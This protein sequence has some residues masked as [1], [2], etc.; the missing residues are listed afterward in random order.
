MR[1]PD[2]WGVKRPAATALGLFAALLAATA[3]DDPRMGELVVGQNTDGRL[4]IFRVAP[5]GELRHRW[6]KVSNGE[7]SSWGG[8]GGSLAPGIAAA[9]TADGGLAV[10]GV[11]K[12]TRTLRYTRQKPPGHTGWSPWQDLGGS[13]RCPVTV[14]R[15]LDGRL[16]MFG[17][18]AGSGAV[19]CI[20]QTNA[21]EGWS[22]WLDLGG[23]LEPGLAVERNRDGCMELF[24]G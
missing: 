2:R 1:M 10:F 19:K 8:L 7:W 3:A 11:D 14:G 4:E 24:A 21:E 16:E 22:A 18:D 23:V 15:N 6:Q 17:V 20:W 5:D 13:L 12:G 9:Q